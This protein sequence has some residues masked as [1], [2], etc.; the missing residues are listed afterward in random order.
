MPDAFYDP[1]DPRVQADPYPFYRR[2]RDEAPVHHVADKD[3][4]VLSRFEDI[5]RAARRP[6]V[7]SSAHGLTF[8]E[9]E[10]QKLGLAPTIVM[11]DAP[12]HT[13]FRRLIS[14]GFTPRQVTRLEE[15]IRDFVVERIEVLRARGEGD[16]IEMLAGPVPTHVLALLMDIPDADRD[17]F[18]PWSSAIVQASA[19][20]ENVIQAA[21]AAV[22]GLYQYF[23]GLIRRR[24]DTPGDDLIS[25]LAAAEVEGEK[26][27]DMEILGF[28]F[29]MVA[30]G[31]DTSTGLIGGAAE[32]L[33]RHPQQRALLRE[34]PARMKGA[35]EEF[36]RLTAPVQGLCRTT[37]EPVQL[38]GVSIPAG[39]KV[40][41]LYASGNV[42]EREFGPDA[43]EL[44]VT[45]RVE[46]M[47][48][49][50]SGPHF[51][52]GAALARMQGQIALQELIGRIPDFVVDPKAG[53][54]A[55]GMFV[56]RW[57]SLPFRVRP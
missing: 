31:N 1:R 36:L 44:D 14:K 49:F 42:D 12:Q 38:H 55:P 50:S 37:L 9:D 23:G 22:M 20:G 48:S 4:Y 17:R 25:S 43:A 32:L 33:W 46:R 51:C 3:F 45:R 24:R 28:C 2:L 18:D 13:Q 5:Y 6:E 41:L 16:L 57:Q 52:L 15:A 40:Q 35:V 11:M 54:M 39:K 8:E 26:L 19:E 47:L 27:T 34:Q 21:A 56:R 10:I 53:R 7:F 29:V 30:G